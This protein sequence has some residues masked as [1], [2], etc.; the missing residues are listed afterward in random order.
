M[1]QLD[2]MDN[3]YNK[4]ITENK[5]ILQGTQSYRYNPETDDDKTKKG[6]DKS[7]LK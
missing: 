5:I 7:K 1:G 2:N 4:S 6:V 3:T